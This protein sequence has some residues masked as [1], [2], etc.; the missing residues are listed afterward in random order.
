MSRSENI[1]LLRMWVNFVHE[2]P[3]I[4]L[5]RVTDF[6]KTPFDVLVIDII[7]PAFSL[8]LENVLGWIEESNVNCVVS[9]RITLPI[10]RNRILVTIH[11]TLFLRKIVACDL[12]IFQPSYSHPDPRSIQ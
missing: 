12:Q 10:Y 8:R 7:S 6:L 5:I 1:V 2:N 4:S 9:P 3:S 11:A